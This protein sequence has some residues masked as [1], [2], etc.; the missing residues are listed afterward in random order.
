MHRI[1]APTC[2]EYQFWRLCRVS[3]PL[4]SHPQLFEPI[5]RETPTRTGIYSRYDPSSSS[6][7]GKC[8]DTSSC[9]PPNVHFLDETTIAANHSKSEYDWG[10]MD[11]PALQQVIIMVG[12]C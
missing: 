7:I 3:F 1:F 5:E 6:G 2:L 12:M 9:Q 4:S 10:I 11:P 8:V